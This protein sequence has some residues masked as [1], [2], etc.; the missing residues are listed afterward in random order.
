MSSLI[1]PRPA[2]S[3]DRVAVKDVPTWMLALGPARCARLIRLAWLLSELASRNTFWAVEL[4]SQ[5]SKMAPVTA[6][7]V[8]KMFATFGLEDAEPDRG[9]TAEGPRPCWRM[10]LPPGPEKDVELDDLVVDA[11]S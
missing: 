9:V 6:L 1:A 5:P 4:C 8:K 3:A 2:C 11:I 10:L 7:T